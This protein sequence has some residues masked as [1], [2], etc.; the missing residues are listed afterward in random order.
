MKA[1]SERKKRLCFSL[2]TI[3]EAGIG[4]NARLDRE[5]AVQNSTGGIDTV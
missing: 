4:R 5:P 3:P 1:K 2:I